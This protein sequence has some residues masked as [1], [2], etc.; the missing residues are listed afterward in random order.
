MDLEI[1]PLLKEFTL[2][3]FRVFEKKQKFELAPLTLLTGKNNSGKSSLIK[4]MNLLSSS[5]RF[6]KGH[7]LNFDDPNLKLA[8]YKKVANKKTPEK[9]VAFKLKL[10]RYYSLEQKIDW[11][12]Y[13]SYNAKG[14]KRI[15]L[16]E[17]KEVLLDVTGSMEGADFF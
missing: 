17:D 10:S 13:L 3:N 15:R 12:M 5:I 8:N 2:K 6:E 7:F 16:K 4:A 11:T 14:L 1:K 9:S